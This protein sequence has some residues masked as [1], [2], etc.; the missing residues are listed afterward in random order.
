M[1]LNFSLPLSII[2]SLISFGLI[3][4]WY[5]MP[6]LSA[7]SRNKAL[8]PL[9]LFHSFRHIGMAFLIPGVTS[10]VLDPRFADPA[11]YGDLVAAV[12]A[13]IVIMALRSQWSVAIP[14]VWIFNI[15]GTL[16]LLN[17]LFQGFRHAPAG[18]FGAMYFVPAIIVP[19]LLVTHYMIFV[20]LVRR[21]KNAEAVN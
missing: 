13:L 4:K 11:A 17:A 16:D 6:S 15:E 1:D 2:L 5:L 19:A 8:V 10:S 20:L 18:D 12:L 9:L 3:G 14:L 7:L 21:G